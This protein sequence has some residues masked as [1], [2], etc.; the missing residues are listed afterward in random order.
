MKNI[1]STKIKKY[2]KLKIWIIFT[3]LKSKRMKALC[4]YYF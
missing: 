1:N 2:L 3:H 4:K